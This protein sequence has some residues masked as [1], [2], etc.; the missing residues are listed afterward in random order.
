M[1]PNSASRGVFRH[2][3]T[4]SCV[5]AETGP[6]VLMLVLS[7]L[8]W[9]CGIRDGVLRSSTIAAISSF[10]N[11]TTFSCPGWCKGTAA[12]IRYRRT[13]IDEAHSALSLKCYLY[14]VYD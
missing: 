11:P 12:S 9:V 8:S 13:S 5:R 1:A 14:A 7:Q 6:Y 10:R 2:T 4:K 3:K